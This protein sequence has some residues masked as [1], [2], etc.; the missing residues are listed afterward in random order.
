[1]PN[2]GDSSVTKPGRRAGFYPGKFQALHQDLETWLY[3]FSHFFSSPVLIL[4]KPFA[5]NPT[6][7]AFFGN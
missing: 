6:D 7:A 5:R 1:M 4:N 3:S 2:Y